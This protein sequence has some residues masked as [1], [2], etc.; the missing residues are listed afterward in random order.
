MAKIADQ[1]KQEILAAV[2]AA[3]PDVEIKPEEI[4]LEHPVVEEFGDYSTNIAL[5]L[6]LPKKSFLDNIDWIVKNVNKDNF[7]KY[8]PLP[9]GRFSDEVKKAIGAKDDLVYL[10]PKVYAKVNGW[11]E[12]HGGHKEIERGY[13]GFLPLFVHRPS[14]LLKDKRSK[15]VFH[16][17]ID[18]EGS[19][20]IVVDLLYWG[21]D[22]AQISSV[23]FA[24]ES[25]LKNFEEIVLDGGTAVPSYSSGRLN[26]ELGAGSRLSSLHQNH[27]LYSTLDLKSQEKVLYYNEDPAEKIAAKIQNSKF[28][29]QT[30][31]GFINFTLP[32]E[33]LVGEMGKIDENYGKSKSGDVVGQWEKIILE[34]SSPNIA[35]PFGIGHLRSTIIGDSIARILESQGYEVLRDNHLGDWGTQFGRVIYAVKTWGNESEIW[36]SPEPVKLLVDLYVKFH[37][38]AELNPKIENEGRAWFAKLEKGDKEARRLWQL[39]VDVSMK[40][41]DRIYQ[42]LG[43]RFDMF[44]GEAFFEDKMQPVI[45]LAERSPHS[46]LS[47]G[48]K[49]IFFDEKLKLPPLMYL[50]SDGA[51]LYATRD[52][53]TDY[54]RINKW[55]TNTLII[56][57]TGLQQQLYWQQ[58]FEAEGLLGI[59][60]K[61]QR[62]AIMH[63]WM[64]GSDGKKFATREGNVIWLEDVINEGV[65]R[66]RKLMD[67]RQMA[68]EMTDAEKNDV[69]TKVAVAGIKYNDLKQGH[70]KDIVFDWDKVVNLEGDSGPYL[71]YTYAR[72]RSVLKKANKPITNIQLANS[73]LVNEELSILRWLYRFPE[74]VEAAAK[75]Y[76]PNVICTYLFELAKRFNNFYNNVPILQTTNYQLMTFR[77]RLTNATA[78][79]LKTGLNLLGI[80][81]L[82]R[83]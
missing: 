54:Y 2:N 39:C 44:L 17:V 66:A 79:I 27:S 70:E 30:R 49:L 35:K 47:D 7:E 15:T 57:E 52:L 65:R 12:G 73:Q 24:R 33:F 51:T 23:Y 60:Q 34:Y 83:M 8:G 48:A 21:E 81:A 42:L 1:I 26:G 9:V 13:W 68:L 5:R 29:I 37:K 6:K 80:E 40:E 28:K 11:L 74:V 75:Q 38:E 77:L 71:Q 19:L 10:K 72:A 78:Q 14:K 55:G 59:C 32:E 53:A 76:A 58:I 82:E 63:G 43:V 18:L 41:F 46:K 56:N 64:L 3:Y 4:S 31:N 69:A 20:D 62:L 45:G 36:N 16:F 22:F 61:N 67:E 50:K 25:Y